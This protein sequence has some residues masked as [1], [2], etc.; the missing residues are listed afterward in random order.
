M[1]LVTSTD[2]LA[3]LGRLLEPTLEKPL[4]TVDLGRV[5]EPNAVGERLLENT[6]LAP[7]RPLFEDGH[8]EAGLPQFPRHE[9]RSAP[10]QAP[11]PAHA[12]GAMLAAP[13]AAVASAPAWRNL[14][15]SVRFISSWPISI[16]SS[17]QK[18]WNAHLP[19]LV[20]S[21]A[22]KEASERE[23]PHA[24]TARIRR[25]HTLT[26]RTRRGQWIGP[27]IQPGL[28]P[29]LRSIPYTNKGTGR[30]AIAPAA[31]HRSHSPVFHR[32][33]SQG[34]RCS[35]LWRRTFVR[36]VAFGS[37]LFS[38]RVDLSMFE[39]FHHRRSGG[40]TGESVDSR[41]STMKPALQD[42]GNRGR[43]RDCV[44]GFWN[45]L[46]HTPRDFPSAIRGR[47]ALSA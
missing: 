32:A 31:S 1:S 35:H 46:P 15:R 2:L 39:T 14:R 27:G 36:F 37:N 8:L 11:A 3:N 10:W 29:E 42:T 33:C 22:L 24:V 47:E 23:C 45:A 5:K 19:D 13:A 26:I 17:S 28:A 30:A 40:Q 4:G 38:Y 20:R 25:M 21:E 16:D 41:S 9:R 12:P 43:S 44:H 34:H 6:V 7:H 18:I